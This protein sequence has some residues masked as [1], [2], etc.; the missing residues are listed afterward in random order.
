MILVHQ[1]LIQPALPLLILVDQGRPYS[2]DSQA[3]GRS[4]HGQPV[5]RPDQVAERRLAD[6][7]HQ[8]EPVVIPDD[9][10]E[11]SAARNAADE[12]TISVTLISG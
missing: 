5:Q 4:E 9:A 1:N 10:P 3:A 2:R 12:P 11:I 8:L 7:L 6:F